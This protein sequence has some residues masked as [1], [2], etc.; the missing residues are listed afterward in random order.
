MHRPPVLVSL[1]TA[2]F[3]IANLTS[4]VVIADPIF[5]SQAFAQ[6]KKKVVK[7]SIKKKSPSK[8]LM[9]R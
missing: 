2:L 1:F 8:R 4:N 9:A 6:Q 3:L 7:K 5:S